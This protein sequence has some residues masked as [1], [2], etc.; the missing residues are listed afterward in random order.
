MTDTVRRFQVRPAAQDWAD[1][2]ADLLRQD[3]NALAALSG[4]MGHTGTK[5]W[6]WRRTK[7]DGTF[8]SWSK[9]MGKVLVLETFSKW[10]AADGSVFQVGRGKSQVR[11]RAAARTEIVR[12][13]DRDIDPGA[14]LLSALIHHRFP[15]IDF[16]GGAVCKTISG[17]PYD[18]SDHSWRDAIDE[19]SAVDGVSNDAVFD[20][21]VRMARA[22]C[23]AFAY[24]IGSRNGSVVSASSPDFSIGV[25]RASSTHL[26]HVHVSIVD[27]GG[28]R[29][30]W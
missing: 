5:D 28:A 26:W 27:H 4:M 14:T 3:D 20:W 22:N 7:L 30:P 6:R 9:P 24:A 18:W 15:G 21:V 16:T 17:Y 25:S 23:T 29:P 19:G 12:L 2:G 8:T 1:P 10:D 11:M 13:A